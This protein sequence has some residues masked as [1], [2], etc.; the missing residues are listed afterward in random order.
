M[1]ILVVL[2]LCS[3]F[4]VDDF[5]AANGQFY[6]DTT[7]TY[8][9]RVCNGEGSRKVCTNYFFTEEQYNLNKI[10]NKLYFVFIILVLVVSSLADFF[11][12]AP[13]D[14]MSEDPVGTIK[15]EWAELMEEN[16][17]Q[18]KD[19]AHGWTSSGIKIFLVILFLLICFSILGTYLER[20][21]F[22]QNI[23]KIK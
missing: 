21:H 17:K 3:Y 1:W 7:H 20:S 12:P 5:K 10:I 16:E 6:Q 9:E 18:K 13:K 19:P 4:F 11:N 8:S 2:G 22:L 23:L 14:K 15:T